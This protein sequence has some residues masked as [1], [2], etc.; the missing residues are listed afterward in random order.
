MLY[1]LIR[2]WLFGLDPHRAQVIAMAALRLRNA[3]ARDA[4]APYMAGAFGVEVMGLRFP[5]RVGLAAGFDKDAY[6]VDSLGRLGFGFIEVGTV[7][8]RPQ[9][10]NPRP[11]LFRL[12]PDEALVNRLGF[13]NEG[14]AAVAHRLESRRYPGILGVNIGKNFDTLLE[15]AVDDYTSC[16]RTIY[17]VADYVTINVSSPNTPGLRGLQDP[18]ALRPLLLEL[19]NLREQLQ[20]VHGKRVPLLV[21]LSPDLT[22]EQLATVSRELRELP[23]DG[24]VATN[25][26]TSRPQPLKSAAATE[27][28]GLSGRPLHARSI[29]VLRSLRAALGPNYPIIGVGGIVSAERGAAT[30]NAGADLLQLYTGLIYQG[31][32]LIREVLDV[33]R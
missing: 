10:G 33:V 1:G 26:T 8:P 15:K 23:V 17:G 11:N 2:P 3:F 12:V 22:D 4:L 18:G 20:P 7:T 6:D 25:T 30:R 29:A 31:P 21:K 24:V 5:N 14:A 16:L 28:G 27:T 13:N 32:A 9:A 19:A